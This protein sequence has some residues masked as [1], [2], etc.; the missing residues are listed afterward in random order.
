[1]VCKLRHGDSKTSKKCHKV[2]C[3]LPCRVVH[4]LNQVYKYTSSSYVCLRLY[5]LKKIKGNTQGLF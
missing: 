4:S 2:I 1:M 5:D 3:I